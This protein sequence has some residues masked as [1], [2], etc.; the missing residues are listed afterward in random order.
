MEIQRIANIPPMGIPHRSTCDTELYG[1][2]IPKDTMILT[3]LHSVHMDTE[4]WGDPHVFR[5][6]R[7]LSEEGKIVYNERYF[8]PFGNGLVGVSTNVSFNA[9]VCVLGKRRCLGEALG[10]SSLF[11]FFTGLMHNFTLN[12]CSEGPQPQVDGI[13]GFTIS[14]QPFK[15]FLIPRID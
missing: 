8:I 1:H 7:F 6:E 5:P 14:P 2:F 15:A 4:F 10:K 9:E 3:S 12:T 13:N 11:L